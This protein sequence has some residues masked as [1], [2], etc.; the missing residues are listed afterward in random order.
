LTF[1]SGLLYSIYSIDVQKG[2]DMKRTFGI[3]F[4]LTLGLISIPPRIHSSD[5][6]SQQ[7]DQTVPPGQSQ[8]LA[9]LEA[10]VD[11]IIAAELKAGNVAGATF[12]FV[13]DGTLFFAKGY[14]YADVKKRKPVVAGETLFRPGS[15]SKL[16]TWTAVMQ[17]YEQGKL[18][19]NADVNTYLTKFKIPETYPEPI[20]LAHLM[21]HTPGFEETIKNMA[22]RT[23]EELISLEEYLETSL[24]ARVYPPGKIAAYSNYGAALA[25]YIVEVVSG[26]PFEDYVEENIF[27]PLGMTRTTF[28]EPLPSHLK[29]SMSV[30]YSYKKG[31]FKAEEFELLNGLYPAGSVSTTATDMA[32]FM[33]AHLQNGRYGEARI[34][35]E[36]TA[37]L[38]HSRL[39]SHNPR[40]DGNAHG[41]WEKTQNGIRMIEHGGDTIYFHSQL[42]LFPEQNQGMF[43]SVNTAD[44]KSDLR[45]HL[46]RSFLDRYFP[47]PDPPEP[48]PLADFKE[49]AK[50]LVGNYMFSRTVY[51]T[52]AKLI[53]LFSQI[54]VKVT[55]EKTLLTSLPMGLGAM[56]WLEVEPYVFEQIDGPGRL[57]FKE[58]DRGKMLYV[59]VNDYPFMAGLRSEWYRTPSFHLFVTAIAVLILVSSLRWP[60]GALFGR[61]CRRKRD[62][63]PAP[64]MARWMA[65]LMALL[66]LVFL[67]GLAA[68]LGDTNKFMFGVPTALKILLGL[69][70]LSILFLVLSL[71]FSILAWTKRYWTGCARLHYTLV[72]LAGLGFLW[73]LNYWNL[74]GWK[75]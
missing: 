62:E 49:R 67:V 7:T 41:F 13:K 40:L 19:L 8:G 73:V 51:T 2:G 26:M 31:I 48:E 10:F 15:V 17:L 25:G 27:R 4:F 72:V 71:V 54:S 58:S 57:M 64:K 5:S 9:D 70:V 14:G 65:G 34:L 42:V 66:L 39:F 29:D 43:V 24:P 36:E 68:L 1:L 74:L 32:K 47:V 45:E 46:L 35:R 60:L 21:S 38:M 28:R 53:A 3:I 12:S 50:S 44:T 56:Q 20:T 59:Y 63:R 55:P 69:P 11:G 6:P 18:D 37:K 33:I 22:V 23:P 16:F 75:F 30:G 52:Y 61:I